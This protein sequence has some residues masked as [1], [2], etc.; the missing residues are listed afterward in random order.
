MGAGSFHVNGGLFVGRRG[1]PGGLGVSTEG[2]WSSNYASPSGEIKKFVV[3]DVNGKTDIGTARYYRD[4]KAKKDP[5]TGKPKPKPAGSWNSAKRQ[6]S[7]LLFMESRS[8]IGTTTRAYV[9]IGRN[10]LQVNP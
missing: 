7:W 8:D 9:K 3:L 10:Y 5:A 1:R 4:L 2:S 6:Q